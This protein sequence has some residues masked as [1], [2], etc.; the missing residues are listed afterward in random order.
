[1]KIVDTSKLIP[2][3]LS[4][5]DREY[6]YNGLDA[7]VTYEVLDVLLPQLTKQTQRTYDFSRALQGP[8]LDMRIRGVKVDKARRA[9][10]TER[11]FDRL[12]AYENA[13]ER[14]VRE[15]FGIYGFN[16]RSTKDL[17]KL[18]YETLELP[19]IKSKT[20]TATV[21][22][23]A[24]EKMEI[25]VKAGPLIHLMKAARDLAKRIQVLKTDIDEDGRMRTSYNIAGT[26]TGR[27]SSS[28]SEFGTGTNLQNIEEFLRSMFI[29]DP[30]MKMANF[31]AEQGESRVVGAIEWNLFKSGR[32]LNACE[33][34]DLHT[35]V[36]RL[37]WPE[38]PWTNDMEKDRE[39]A[40][41]KYYREHTYRF[42]C[43]K[44]GHGAN[45]LGKP[46][47]LAA[48][49]KTDI[50]KASEFYNK[51][52]TIFPGHRQWHDWVEQQLLSHGRLTTL[53]GRLR[54]FFGRRDSND[55][56]RDAIAYDP[57]GSLSDI[58]NHGML[59]VW[60][61]ND[62]QLLLQVH[63]SIVV[64]YP[65]EKE[66]EI[67]PKILKQLEYPIQLQHNRTLVIPYGCK[68]GW[69]WG[70]F[71]DD[72]TKGALNLDGLKKYQPNDK[73]ARTPEAIIMDRVVC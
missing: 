51:Y 15:A 21:N 59:N 61:A 11:L 39:I 18:F 8:V 25:Y 27:F 54:Y 1:M 10:V 5:S 29:A 56:L 68:T 12:T 34:Q 42:M 71:N 30:G 60:R 52:M 19:I 47:T 32:Y 44:L 13:I 70:E 46:E 43:K 57:Q 63:D 17:R 2:E 72:P 20:G 33:S 37:C 67:I 35:Y 41:R 6:V 40:E 36:A 7:C 14:I 58:V 3:D 23:A 55:V 50:V 65:E 53:T 66:D 24:L 49:T 62:C 64:Q 16:W 26:T 38:L 69:N 31:D 48:Q 28:Y 45:Y 22:R 73:R 4:K 9:E